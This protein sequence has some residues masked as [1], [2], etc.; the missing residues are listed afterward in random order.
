MKVDRNLPECFP[1]GEVVR[2]GMADAVTA[3]P[4]QLT[5]VALHQWLCAEAMVGR[6][7]N[8]AARFQ[9]ASACRV[10]TKNDLIVSR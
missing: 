3:T 10:H 2:I 9:D 8:G 1:G 4:L 7:M 6:S 5:V